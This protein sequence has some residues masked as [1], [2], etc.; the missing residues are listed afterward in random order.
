MASRHVR[1][2]CVNVVFGVLLA[3]SAASARETVDRPDRTRR[4]DHAASEQSAPT[5]PPAPPEVIEADL[6]SP[7]PGYHR[8]ARAR[9]GR[10]LGGGL[11]FAAA[12]APALLFGVEGMTCEEPQPGE[13]YCGFVRQFQSAVVPGIGP[14]LVLDACNGNAPCMA[15]FAADAGLQCAGL[16]LFVSGAVKRD[17]YVRDAETTAAPVALT[18]RGTAGGAVL[19]VMG[20]F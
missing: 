14:L 4:Q 20:N 3:A 12:W 1:R 11:L 5:A 10:A 8:E 13:D 19:G 15:I 18:L 7:P 17:V 9:P 16:Y 2:R 6:P